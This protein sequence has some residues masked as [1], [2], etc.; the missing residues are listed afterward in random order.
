M[1]DGFL[2]KTIYIYILY[3]RVTFKLSTVKQG[4]TNALCEPNYSS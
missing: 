3:D 4:V 1:I 2:L